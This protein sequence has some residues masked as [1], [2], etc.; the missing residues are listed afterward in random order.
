MDKLEKSLIS[1][2]GSSKISSDDIL[3]ILRDCVKNKLID[4]KEIKKLEPMTATDLL[5]YISKVRRNFLFDE[6]YNDN[7]KSFFDSSSSNNNYDINNKNLYTEYLDSNKTQQRDKNLKDISNDIRN[8]I[9]DDKNEN[10]RVFDENEDYAQS[11]KNKVIKSFL[12]YEKISVNNKSYPFLYILLIL[13]I[14]VI[15]IFISYT[16]E[17]S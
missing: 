15:F 4:K 12:E 2:Y 10:R 3:N 17:P 16:P 13:I 1:N 8:N 11:I 7:G 5:E 9:N 14:I 6:N